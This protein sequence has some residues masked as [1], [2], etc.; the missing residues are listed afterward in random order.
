MEIEAQREGA[1]GESVRPRPEMLCWLRDDEMS[2]QEMLQRV[3]CVIAHVGE[4]PLRLTGVS[5]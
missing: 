3:R 5:V 2:V 4:S 1:G